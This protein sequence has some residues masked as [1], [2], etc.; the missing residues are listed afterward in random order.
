MDEARRWAPGDVILWRYERDAQV[1]RVVRDDTDGLVAWLAPGSPRLAVVPIDG[2]AVR[3]RPPAERFTMPRRYEV[4]T[5]TGAG[6]LRLERPGRAHSLWRFADPDTGVRGWYANLEDPLRRSEDAVHTADHVLD[7][8]LDDTGF[9]LWKDEDE[10]D[11]MLDLGLRSAEWAAT[12]R[13]EGE[14]VIAA[15]EAG[16]PPFDGSWRDWEPD[17]AWPLPDLPADLAALDGRPAP[18]F[19]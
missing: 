12:V 17:P 5:W 1:V 8:W 10:M 6:I 16:E 9:W 11:A 3:D 4:T 13:A 19:S 7:V 2:A 14:A 15:F 18:G